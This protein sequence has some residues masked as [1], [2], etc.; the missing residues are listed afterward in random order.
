[1]KRLCTYLFVVMLSLSL[2]LACGCK[3]GDQGGGAKSAGSK[4]GKRAINLTMWQTMDPHELETFKT[5]VDKFHAS[6]DKIAVE[7]Q[8]VPFNDAREKFLRAAKGNSAPDVLR[9][10]IAWTPLFADLGYLHQIESQIPPDDLEDYLDAPLN[11]NKY[12]GHLY[13]I[14]QVTDCLALIYN[15]RILKEAGVAVPRTMDELLAASVKLT[16]KDKDRYGIFIP[17]D[18]YFVQPFIWAFGGGLITDDKKV[19]IANEASIAGFEFFLKLRKQA[20]PETIN[21]ATQNK[22]RD[23]GFKAG[24]YAMVF[25]GPWATADLIKG[26]QF[27]DNPDNL[28]IARIPKGPKGYGSPVGGHN[29]V[30]ARNCN[31]VQAAVQ[32]IQFL[33]KTE[34]QV[35]LAVKNNLLPTR[36]SAYE[37]PA[38]KKLT[39]LQGFK[40]QL[41]VANNRPVIPEGGAIYPD[42]TRHVQ[43]AYQ[44]KTSAKKAMEGTAADWNKLLEASKQAK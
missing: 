25:Q 40:R 11:Y 23:E 15:K 21:I 22:E 4:V 38:V 1:M 14:P 28:G 9:C 42:F 43:E 7:I 36:K 3:G 6:Q 31:N 24:R 34:N 18:G 37:D 35:L 16:Q 30:I 10:E 44:G 29:Y 27:K 8:V 20:M 32:F 2:V 17:A 19:L 41:E 26:K 33:N 12:Q 39:I 13:G 5:I